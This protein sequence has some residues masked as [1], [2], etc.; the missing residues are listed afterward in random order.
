MT[1]FEFYL[2]TDFKNKVVHMRGRKGHFYQDHMIDLFTAYSEE[3]VNEALTLET[4]TDIYIEL[5][6]RPLRRKKI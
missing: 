2:Q 5:Y 4:E 3:E 6:P 1:L